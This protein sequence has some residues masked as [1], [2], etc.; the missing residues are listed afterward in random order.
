[1]NLLYVTW[2][3]PSSTYL[4]SLFLPIF[5]ALRSWGVFTHVLQLSWATETFLERVEA[6][7]TRHGVTIEVHSVPRRPLQAATAA[8]IALGA[9][10]VGRAVKRLSADVLVPRS[11]IPAAIALTA[12]SWRPVRRLVWDSDGLV[13]DERADFGQWSREGPTY[14]VFRRVEQAIVRTADATI[15]R[16]IRAAAILAERTG[17][18]LDDFQIVPNGK[19]P[20]RF[21]P[22]TT[23]DRLMTRQRL[24]VPPDAPLLTHVGSVGPQ[25]HLPKALAVF[26]R[27]RTRLPQAHMLILTGS[28]DAAATYVRQ[29]RLPISAVSIDCVEPGQVGNLL[30][31]CDAG[32][33]FREPSFSQRAVCPIKVAEYLLSGVPVLGNRGVGDLDAHLGN[34]D[35]AI[36]SDGLGA[37]S[38]GDL[39]DR[40]VEEMWPN[41]ESRRQA[42]RAVGLRWHSLQACVRGYA[43]ALGVTPPN[44]DG[45]QAD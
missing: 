6:A 33:A 4:E 43:R 19:D 21:H 39:A 2:D 35:A 26:N 40:F 16:T 27:I 18:S 5:E 14:K 9:I 20:H 22:G 25:Y 42:C 13:P 10:H 31:A 30:P 1:M 8:A 32:F 17:R 36:L 24:G 37:L 23:A 45:L 34:S 28:L 38:L 41:R 29:A 15:T 12:Q 3:G 7:A 44:T 11:H